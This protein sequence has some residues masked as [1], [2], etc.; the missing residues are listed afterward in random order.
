MLTFIFSRIHVWISFF[1]FKFVLPWAARQVLSP[2]WKLSDYFWAVL[3]MGN[4]GR[5]NGPEQYLNVV[6][7]SYNFRDLWTFGLFI[8]LASVY[9]AVN[10][11]SHSGY[12]FHRAAVAD[13]ENTLTSQIK[14]SIRNW[15]GQ[16]W[17]AFHFQSELIFSKHSEI[18]G[19]Q[20]L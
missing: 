10:Q 5:Q 1:N 20:I 3:Y 2:P 13:L 4:G 7:F 16:V 18:S 12:L 9:P 14:H 19:R 15:K 8:S 17:P 6:K 11:L